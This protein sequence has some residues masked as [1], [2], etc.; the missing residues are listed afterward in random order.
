M[1]NIR[2][3]MSHR[4]KIEDQR[5]LYFLTLTVAGWV[6]VFS[7][8]RY[9]DI[10]LESLAYCKAHKDL[11]IY[12]YVIMSNHLH[13]IASASGEQTLS[14]VMGDFKSFT[15][16]AILKS[17]KTDIESRRDWLLYLFNFFA[18]KNK[19]PSQQQFWESDN[20]PI[21]LFSEKVIV[22]KLDYIHYNPVREGIV[23]LP[24]HYLYSS[25]SNYLEQGE[26]IF[27]VELLDDYFS[28]SFQK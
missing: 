22:Q 13:L 18:R 20:H 5:S 15:A 28:P 23:N 27:D 9:K 19:K 10:L 14:E 11:H 1:T 26:G 6:D 24:Q 12:G 7:R 3:N 25:A 17:I 21:I 2:L 16:K 8:K 4:Y